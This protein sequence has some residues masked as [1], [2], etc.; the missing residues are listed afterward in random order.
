MKI[1][2]LNDIHHRCP[3]WWQRLVFWCAMRCGAH[4]FAW[5]AADYSHDSIADQLIRRAAQ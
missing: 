2:Y 4:A 1:D 5:N 3:I